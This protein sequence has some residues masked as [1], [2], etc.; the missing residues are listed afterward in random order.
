MP[1]ITFHTLGCKL[2]F[3]ETSTLARQF[4][5]AG[6]ECVDFDSAADI[7]VLNTCSVTENADQKCRRIIRAVKQRAPDSYVA[8]VGCYAQ[9]QAE[10]IGRIEGV[11]LVLGAKEKFNL[12]AQIEAR[13][14]T[15]EALVVRNPIEKKLPFHSSFSLADRTRTFLKIQDGCNYNCSFCTI[16]LA[17]GASRSQPIDEIIKQAEEIGQNGVREIVLTGVNS[18]DYGII[19]GKRRHTFFDL[20]RTLEKVKTIKRFRIS[21]IEPNLLSDDIIDFVADSERFVPHFHMPLQAGQDEVL[22]AMRRR[23]DTN[24]F[25]RRVERIKMKMPEAAIGIDVIVGFP[26]ESQ[27]YFE[28]TY[29]FLNELPCSYLHVFTYSERPNTPASKLPQIPYAV[30]KARANELRNLSK[31]KKETFYKSQIGKILPSYSSKKIELE[32][33]SVLVRIIF[34]W[35]VLIILL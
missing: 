22:K 17:R 20:L 6:Y 10:R 29:N 31:I 34:G 7:F 3:S 13:K 28:A 14:F 35:L 5:Q 30:R 2:N 1:K 27:T 12:V 9:L 8:V 32:I 21:S 19:G 18:G 11:N 33:C 26:T 24:L 16:P 15:S 23:Y 25:R 4:R